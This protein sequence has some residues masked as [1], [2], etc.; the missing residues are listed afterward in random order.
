[1]VAAVGPLQTECRPAVRWRDVAEI[2]ETGAE[3]FKASLT[4]D[5]PPTELLLELKA[6]LGQADGLVVLSHGTLIGTGLPAGETFRGFA[7][8]GSEYV[9]PCHRFGHS[10]DEEKRAHGGRMLKSA[11]LTWERD[12]PQL[13]EKEREAALRGLFTLQQTGYPRPGWDDADANV[14]AAW[15]HAGAGEMVQLAALVRLR[16][17]GPNVAVFVEA[18]CRATG[19]AGG[20]ILADLL[21]PLANA[22]RV[23][24]RED[25]LLPAVAAVR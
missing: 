5:H 4:P 9:M 19:L 22:G 21:L 18:S 11:E 3:A 23:V 14:V 13:S 10:T 17:F 15:K 16:C 12:S 8:P 7:R 20:E 24:F 1:M 2:A 6:L 25:Y